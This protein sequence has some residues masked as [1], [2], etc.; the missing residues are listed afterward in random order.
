MVSILI[1]ISIITIVGIIVYFIFRKKQIVK[2]TKGGGS[3]YGIVDG[4]CVPGKGTQTEMKCLIELQNRKENSWG[5]SDTGCKE[6]DGKLSKG[7]CE[8][9]CWGVSADGT[10]TVNSG[11]YSTRGDC[12]INSWGCGPLGGCTKGAG[13]LTEDDCKTSSCWGC[14]DTGGCG[15]NLGKYETEN[16]CKS[17]DCYG[18]STAAG[19]GCVSGAGKWTKKVCE[20]E[21]CW[22]C[23][24][25]G[26]QVNKGAFTKTDCEGTNCWGC[27]DTGC[28]ANKGKYNTSA[29]CINATNADP[30]TCFGIDTT[31]FDCVKNKGKYKTLQDCKN[32][33]GYGCANDGTGTGTYKCLQG[34]GIYTDQQ[35]CERGT[36]C[37]G[38]VNG[39]AVEGK[40]TGTDINMSCC[41][42]LKCTDGPQ[43]CCDNK[44]DCCQHSTAANGCCPATI[45]SCTTEGCCDANLVY[46]EQNQK[47]CCPSAKQLNKDKTICCPS[48]QVFQNGSCK[49]PCGKNNF[50]DPLLENCFNQTDSSG[51]II[52]SY[53]FTN[54]CEWNYNTQNSDP[55]NIG[56]SKI[57]KSTAT[58]D[59]YY[60]NP[61]PP[62]ARTDLIKTDVANQSSKV[63]C[64]DNDCKKKFAADVKGTV[65]LANKVCTFKPNCN[66]LLPKCESSTGCPGVNTR[67]CKTPGNV[68]TGK[69]CPEN[70]FCESDKCYKSHVC[71]FDNDTLT[72]SCEPAVYDNVPAQNCDNCLITRFLNQEKDFR[73]RINII[74]VD[75]LGNVIV[76]RNKSIPLTN[77]TKITDEMIFR[78]F[79]NQGA[80]RIHNP[81]NNLD[82]EYMYLS[83]DNSYYFTFRP[84]R[85]GID[86]IKCRVFS[87]PGNP[88]TNLT[89]ISKDIHRPVNNT[90][91]FNWKKYL[92]V[93][94]V[95]LIAQTPPG[96]LN[97]KYKA[98]EHRVSRK[99]QDGYRP[100]S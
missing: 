76:N 30:G 83:V 63:D 74:L 53:C 85:G 77:I 62:N 13:K 27:G 41:T 36:K 71:L 7:D 65:S 97:T 50:C 25:T 10:C 78:T 37:V 73:L 61:P 80:N 5:C 32:D 16:E 33:R 22:G 21:N 68:L 67:C 92:T 29:D 82:T 45:P 3:T 19:V 44:G 87:I 38:C 52:D 93:G 96:D 81:T 69:I 11:N 18:C 2:T 86:D 8:Q 28:Q 56:T 99:N 35:S 49:T 1:I 34:H 4:N 57:C 54:G 66:T 42:K 12:E 94:G 48:D 60:C 88:N 98:Q 95:D 26:C 6:G 75:S 59:L 24:D 40:G 46:T 64:K 23:G 58:G 91:V 79:Y 31:N 15:V 9:S 14:K 89:D 70:S 39:T 47:R 90:D 84:I 55:L 51:V 17:V 72:K 100:I 43:T 20:A